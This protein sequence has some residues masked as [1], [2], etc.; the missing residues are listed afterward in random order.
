MSSVTESLV[1]YAIPTP[2]AATS[3]NAGEYFSSITPQTQAFEASDGV[4]HM[5]VSGSNMWIALANGGVE[6]REVHTGILQHVFSSAPRPSSST[7]IWCI[8]SV[9]AYSVSSAHPHDSHLNP[10]EDEEPQVWLGLSTGT[11]EI[12]HGITYRLL[13]QLH[14]HLS[15]V[16]CLEGCGSGWKGCD[17]V[18]YSGSSDFLI[19]QWKVNVGQ[20]LRI[21][22]G[23]SNYVRCL[24]AEGA[25]L[26]SG[27]DDCN[28]RVWDRESGET[29]RV[30]KFHATT[31]GV[32]AI[33]RVGV[34]MW[35]GD[36]SGTLV[37][38]K[39][40]NCAVTSTS[41]PHNGR[42]TTLQ[43]IGSRVYSGS[44][45]GT[46]GLYNAEDEVMLEQLSHHAASGSRVVM[47]RCAVE[48]D[49]YYVWSCGADQIIRCWHHD[50]A[51]PMSKFKERL[52]DMRWYYETYKPYQEADEKLLDTHHELSEYLLLS[53]G[54]EED[55]KAYISC[56]PSDKCSTALKC[57]ILDFKAN[58]A[59]QR[60]SQLEMEKSNLDS[61]IQERKKALE[62]IQSNLKA[63]TE[64]LTS[65]RASSLTAA[66]PLLTQTVTGATT[67]PIVQP[68]RPTSVEVSAPSPVV[69]V[70]FSKSYEP[71][72]SGVPPPLPSNVPVKTTIK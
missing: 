45:D 9:R 42:I 67:A 37:I 47:V 43:K 15:G 1:P 72:L 59:N 38:W 54:T 7:R 70:A 3:L 66:S 57:K 36:D 26:V 60:V 4:V 12:Y 71:V 18:V 41:H 40:R 25:T 33:C 13:Q 49:R 56:I 65:A 24:Y 68:L 8:L 22:K 29:L 69:Q 2:T 48:V 28:V 11:I 14:K 64:A 51:I 20:L 53:Q 27:S 61:Q 10:S 44:A 62:V 5:A 50:E 21:F 30:G 55:I 23:H 16:Y 6:V 52:N 58:E 19:A 63:M 46:I 31:G 17:D 34:K 39:I 35:T 32:S